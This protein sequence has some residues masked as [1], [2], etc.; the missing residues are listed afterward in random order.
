MI[1]TYSALH[2]QNLGDIHSYKYRFQQ[3]PWILYIYIILSK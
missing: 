3:A 2:I 1:Y